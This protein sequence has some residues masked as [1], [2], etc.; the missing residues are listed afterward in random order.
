MTTSVESSQQTGT[1]PPGTTSPDGAD[2]DVAAAVR[3]VARRSKVAA[4]ALATATRATKDAALA[5]LADALVA[6]TDRI[7]AANAVD[8][9]R[10]RAAATSPGL[11]DR[12]A[13]TPDRIAA[14]AD[15]LRELAALP[16]PAWDLV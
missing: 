6:A 5:G 7:V 3:D 16:D 10:G 14:I 11:L 15:A 1:A 2:V 8:L 12:L 4:R 13:L 9:E